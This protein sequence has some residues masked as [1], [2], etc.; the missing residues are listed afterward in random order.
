MT[1]EPVDTDRTHGSRSTL[2]RTRAVFLIL[3]AAFLLAGIGCW[4]ESFRAGWQPYVAY[5]GAPMQVLPAGDTATSWWLAGLASMSA[6]VGTTI[7]AVAPKPFAAAAVIAPVYGVAA[8]LF[9]L[10]TAIA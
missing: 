3:A 2:T 9:F 7:S 1:N 4:I 8:A 6:G 10:V 5:W